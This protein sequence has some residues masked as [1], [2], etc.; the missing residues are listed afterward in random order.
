M[1]LIFLLPLFRQG[2]T[3][4]RIIETFLAWGGTPIMAYTGRLHPKGLLSSGF[5]YKRVGISLVGV[6]QKVE[7]IRHC[8]L[9]KAFY[10]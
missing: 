5:R 6:Y 2:C 7:E 1:A 10:R 3:S 9:L 4:G 8:V